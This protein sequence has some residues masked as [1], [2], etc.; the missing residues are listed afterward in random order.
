MEGKY[1]STEGLS[2]VFNLGPRDDDN[3]HNFRLQRAEEQTISEEEQTSEPALNPYR[4][5]AKSAHL[6]GDVSTYY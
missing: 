2:F 1:Y 6:D 5:A 3:Y 4:K